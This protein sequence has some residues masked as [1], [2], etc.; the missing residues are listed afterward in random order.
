M[1]EVTIV[2]YCDGFA[3]DD[4]DRARSSIERVVAVDNGRPV[5]LDLCDSCDTLVESMLHLMERGAVAKGPGGRK[6]G[7]TTAAPKVP[8]TA[9]GAARNNAPLTSIPFEGPHICPV[10]K[11][12]GKDFES[13]S[14]SALGQHL[15]SRHGKG[16]KDFIVHDQAS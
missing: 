11:E 16:F 12:E 10:C 5:T 6:K 2:S 1:K 7:S 13:R 14:R 8:P 3:H 15:S 9:A 4:G